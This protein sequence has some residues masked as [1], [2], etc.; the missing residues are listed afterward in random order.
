M[1]PEAGTDFLLLKQTH[2]A[3]YFKSSSPALQKD[4]KY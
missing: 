1:L 3:S 4:L 2:A